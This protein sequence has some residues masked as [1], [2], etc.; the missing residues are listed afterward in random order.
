MPG[1]RTAPLSPDDTG[2][3]PS[4]PLLLL[5]LPLPLPPPLDELGAALSPL[6]PP[7]PLEPVAPLSPV[8]PE[9]G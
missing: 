6:P 2:P 7:E 8:L 1:L 9:G 5:P 4:S 3:L